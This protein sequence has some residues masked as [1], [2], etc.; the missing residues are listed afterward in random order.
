M[1]P[2]ARFDVVVIG[3][4]PA[5]STAATYLAR[6][7]RRVLVLEKEQFPRFHVGESLLPYNRVLFEEMGVLQ[8]LA[9]AGFPRK[10]GAQFHLG[11][12][13][14]CAGFVFREGRFTREPEAMQV[15]R[16][17]FDKILLDHAAAS[18]A[19]VRERT[20]VVT[21]KDDQQGSVVLE[22]DS[23]GN[24]RSSVEARFV[25]DASGRSN[26]TGN[27]EGLKVMHRQL[28]KLSVFGHFKGVR[29]DPGER[30]GDTV[31]TRLEKGWF[32]IIPIGRDKTS[33]GCVFDK[34]E[35]GRGEDAAT[36]AFWGRVRSSS[37]M[38]E[39]MSG[40]SLVGDLH[41]TTDF[42][43]RNRK[44]VGER[45]VR[46]G[47]AAGFIDPI[48]SSGVYL[49]MVSARL[50]SR[51]IHQVFDSD[52]TL[53]MEAFNQYEQRVL[54]AMDF[55]WEMV[56]RFYTTPFIEILMHPHPRWGL[57]AA[58]N[59]MLAGDL[60]NRWQLRWRLRLFHWLVR[61]QSKWPV[62]PRVSFS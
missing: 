45:V 49:A 18:G 34:E 6:G 32:W 33:V 13:S 12:G 61:L 20:S 28:R 25:V 51:T 19:E 59:A 24:G 52:S 60:E 57:A 40:A 4:G 58:V 30:A 50:A 43:Y 23:P 26:V 38:Q 14:C 48:F 21:L 53:R 55:Y 2:H 7:G 22:L 36:E 56:E 27:L 44:L 37:V 39:R 46:V 16:S 15:E 41:V 62:A 11:N 35:F 10:L 42:S 3:G 54:E 8:R 1:K 47:D 5:G 31:I 29:L 17:V 9:A